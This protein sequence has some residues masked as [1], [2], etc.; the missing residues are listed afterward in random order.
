[1]YSDEVKVD[2]GFHDIFSVRMVGVSFSPMYPR[3][4]ANLKIARNT[5]SSLFN[6]DVVGTLPFHVFGMRERTI[7]PLRSYMFV[8]FLEP[9]PESQ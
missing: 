5:V 7:L 6:V 9:S 8:R 3:L 4:T 2:L 1:M